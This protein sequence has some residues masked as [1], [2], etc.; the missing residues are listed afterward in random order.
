MSINICNFSDILKKDVFTENGGYSGSVSEIIID[1]QKFK[2]SGIK[3]DTRKGAVYSEINAT[4]VIVPFSTITAIGDIVIMKHAK[5][6]IAD[7]TTE[8]TGI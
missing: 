2:V 1:V 8:D 6:K 7:E 3:V 5:P 4:G